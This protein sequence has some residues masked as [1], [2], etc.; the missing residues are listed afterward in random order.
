MASGCAMSFG[1][2]IVS[3]VYIMAHFFGLRTDHV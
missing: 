1:L 3:D 2:N